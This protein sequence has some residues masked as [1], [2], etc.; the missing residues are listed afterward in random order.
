M[1]MRWRVLIGLSTTCLVVAAVLIAS[2]IIS[3]EP[4]LKTKGDNSMSEY[5]V[6]KNLRELQ[7]DQRQEMEFSQSLSIEA[8][9]TAR[10]LVKIWLEKDA[11]MSA[12]ALSI[13]TQ[14]EDHAI[15]P[16]LETIPEKPPESVVMAARLAVEAE[17]GVR[18]KLIAALDA[19]L[20]NKQ[21]VPQ[22]P[23]AATL[24]T[25]PPPLR[26]CDEAYVLMRRIVHFGEDELEE[27]VG[28]DAFLN[29]P[30]ELKNKEIAQARKTGTWRRLVTGGKP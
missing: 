3:E 5:R 17:L 8:R 18:S 1:S 9:E 23:A 4:Q 10:A 16:L 19:M 11:G 30:D 15:I 24:E 7:A 26:V 6:R 14:I 20:D 22:S 21:S 2:Y 29:L 12:K 13:L 28:V 27:A 25:P